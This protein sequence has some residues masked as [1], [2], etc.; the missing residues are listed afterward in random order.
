VATVTDIENNAR[1]NI[2]YTL[3]GVFDF[4][5]YRHKDMGPKYHVLKLFSQYAGL[6]FQK[7]TS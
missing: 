5:N 7:S 6:E 3:D 2:K 1:N 4:M